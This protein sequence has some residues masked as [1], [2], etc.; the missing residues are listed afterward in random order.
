M[1]NST[2]YTLYLDQNCLKK[3]QWTIFLVLKCS[4]QCPNENLNKIRENLI[5]CQIG[6][7]NDPWPI[8]C[9]LMTI[10]LKNVKWKKNFGPEIFIT[11]T[12]WK[13]KE[14]WRN[15][16]NFIFWQFGIKNGHFHSLYTVSRL[17]FFEKTFNGLHFCS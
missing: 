2:V 12:L 16:E 9:I 11:V 15:F 6:I 5:F 3:R 8:Y 7:K 13:F 1:F 17:Q 10:F 4:K 14:I